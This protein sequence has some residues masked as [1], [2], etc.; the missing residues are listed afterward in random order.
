[1]WNRLVHSYRVCYLYTITN[2]IVPVQCEFVYNYINIYKYIVEVFRSMLFVHKQV[3]V[4]F[5][6][7]DICFEHKTHYFVCLEMFNFFL[8][9]SLICSWG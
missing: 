2:K 8:E 9:I 7:G 5:V 3:L 6:S 4:L 1:M